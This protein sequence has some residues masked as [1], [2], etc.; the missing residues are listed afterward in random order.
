MSR[1]GKMYITYVHLKRG[2][3]IDYRDK[4]LFFN[5]EKNWLNIGLDLDSQVYIN[6]DSVESYNTIFVEDDK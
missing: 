1:I 3:E 6:L 5:L 4:P 2:L